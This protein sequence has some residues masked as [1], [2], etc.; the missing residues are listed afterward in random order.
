MAH[1]KGKASSINSLPPALKGLAPTPAV[2]KLAP[3]PIPAAS[4]PVALPDVEWT[5]KP[6][7]LDDKGN[8]AGDL[9]DQITVG[10][11]FHLACEGPSVALKADQ[12]ALELPKAAK[13]QLRILK[14]I[15]I[16]DTRGEFI[17]TTWT[18]GQIKFKD[19]ILTDGTHRV[20]LGSF[21][22]N[23]ASVIVP[24][25]NPESKPI[26]PFG[27]I[28]LG[29]PIWIWFALGLVA[30]IIV[31]VL[32]ESGRRVVKSRR[33]YRMLEKNKIALSPYN[34]FNKDLRKLHRQVSA[35]TLPEGFFPE[36]NEVFRWYLTRELSIDALKASSSTILRALKKSE[37]EL[38]RRLN[39]DLALA[40]A[41]LEKANY[42]RSRPTLDDAYQLIELCRKVADAISSGRA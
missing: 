6:S 34:Q 39:H 37:F 36:L 22:L 15:A 23:V 13:Y 33:F 20:G 21:D 4:A 25:K 16:S 7:K 24:E 35:G 12:L 30:A 9:I 41:E 14:T 18:T 11:K 3:L 29:W 38:Y 42:S 5:C 2:Q 32:L 17:A 28:Y 31:G 40:L 10:A 1:G 8:P 27:P 19:P 26:G